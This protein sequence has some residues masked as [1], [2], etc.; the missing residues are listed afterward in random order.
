MTANL[1]L[2]DSS[3]KMLQAS[4]M[5]FL[6]HMEPITQVPSQDSFSKVLPCVQEVPDTALA[7]VV[8]DLNS[9]ILLLVK[10]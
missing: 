1:P 2:S 5:W 6:P 9:R 10:L 8:L 4:G 7:E 3:S